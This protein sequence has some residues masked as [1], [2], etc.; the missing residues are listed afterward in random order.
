MLQQFKFENQP[1]CSQ[2]EV[3]GFGLHDGRPPDVR[4]YEFIGTVN[5]VSVDGILNWSCGCLGHACIVI[6]QLANCLYG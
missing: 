4:L 3:G 5:S 6:S 1:T 2:A